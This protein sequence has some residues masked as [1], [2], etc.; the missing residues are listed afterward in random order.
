MRDGCVLRACCGTLLAWPWSSEQEYDRL[1]LGSRY[2]VEEQ[3][4]GGQ[5][6]YTSPERL[7]DCLSA[8]WSRL[9]WLAESGGLPREVWTSRYRSLL[10]V[11]AGNGAMVAQA[12]R[13]GFYAI[14]IEPS[15]DLCRMALQG[16]N[17]PLIQGD[18]HLILKVAP[19]SWT[20]IT[21]TDLIEHVT[22]PERCLRYMLQAGRFVYVETPDWPGGDPE[23]WEHGRHI[24]PRQ[25]PCLFSEHALHRLVESA[26]GD[27]RRIHRPIPGKLAMLASLG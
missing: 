12:R 13:F 14:G 7:R 5:L 24:R 15:A 9:G 16:Q 6:P 2:A 23:A 22:E 19:R 27:V 20:L 4:A 3:L 25:H 21:C 11:G 18:Y 10:D 26:G 17:A 8:A 1:Y